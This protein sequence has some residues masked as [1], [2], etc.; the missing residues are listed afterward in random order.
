MKPF[1]LE[2][3]LKGA[4]L[5]N[6]VTEA[7]LQG[8]IAGFPLHVVQAMCDEQVRQG[9]PFST[10][11]FQ[12]Q[13]EADLNHGG[14]DWL[15]SKKGCDFWCEI[16]TSRD[17]DITPSPKAHPHAG[18]MMKYA[19][20]AQTTDKPWKHFQVQ[21][22][23][24]IW[25]GAAAE[26]PFRAEYAY[27]LK[28]ARTIRIGKYDV[29]EPVREPLECGQVYFIPDLVELRFVQEFSWQGNVS[30]KLFLRRGLIHLTKEA[31]V[32][33]AEALLSLTK[34]AD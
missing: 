4:V 18:L 7:D 25:V 3:A 13:C 1:Y 9:N 33:H 5:N 23:G 14:F 11:V 21:V 31:T 20:I 6:T 22:S 24:G 15:Q 30:D 34:A 28:P 8:E 26:L 10:A 2:A 32:I 17:F 16:I 12:S 27:R 29:P 19:K